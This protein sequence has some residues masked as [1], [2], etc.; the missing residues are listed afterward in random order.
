MSLSPASPQ[1][2][3]AEAGAR[4]FE[5]FCRGVECFTAPDPSLR[6]TFAARWHR[7]LVERA[8]ADWKT[9]LCQKLH[10][11]APGQVLAIGRTRGR[12]SAS[13]VRQLTKFVEREG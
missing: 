7:E 5:R 11:L 4:P 13:P 1:F 12:Q 8:F 2:V 10:E 3:G 6:R 9:A